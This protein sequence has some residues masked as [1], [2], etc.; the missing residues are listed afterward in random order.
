MTDD[1]FMFCFFATRE[2]IAKESAINFFFVL[3]LLFFEVLSDGHRLT[4]YYY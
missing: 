1:V 3:F 4:Y 2:M